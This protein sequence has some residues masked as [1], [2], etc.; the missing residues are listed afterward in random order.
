MFVLVV[1]WST[2][3]SFRSPQNTSYLLNSDTRSKLKAALIRARWLKAWGVLPSCSPLWAI[4]SENIMRWLEKLSMFSNKLMARTRYLGSY[5]LAR[6]IASTSQ[7]V[8]M[9]KAP[10]RPPT[11]KGKST[12]L[13]SV[14]GRGCVES[15]GKNY[16]IAVWRKGWRGGLDCTNHRPTILYRTDTPTL[17]SSTLLSRA[18]AGCDPWY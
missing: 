5:T 7:N 6:V 18:G 12:G 1:N 10:S 9:L 11:P 14:T 2:S 17:C 3:P 13:V 8:H 4:S 15:F 16:A